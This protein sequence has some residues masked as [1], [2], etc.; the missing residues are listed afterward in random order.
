MPDAGR[1][2]CY[3]AP[4][5]APSVSVL[6][7]SWQSGAWLERCVR[8]IGPEDAELIV[9]DNASTDGS[10][11]RARAAAPHAIVLA[12]DRNRGFAG[13]VNAARRAAHAPRLLLLNPDAAATPGA[14]ARLAAALDAAPDIGAAAGRLVGEDGVQ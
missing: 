11:D 8:S 5:P 9:A 2:C 3:S 6:V 14:V 12:L 7:V 10:A 13:G 1:T 4:V